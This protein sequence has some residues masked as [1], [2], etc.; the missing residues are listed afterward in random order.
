MAGIHDPNTIDLVTHD[1][2]TD[3]YAL[4]MIETRLWENSAEQIAQLRE[5][6]NTY[7]MYALDEGLIR[8]YPDAASKPLRI[9][10]DCV[11]PPNGEVADLIALAN[12]RLEEHGIRF[13]VNVLP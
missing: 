2:Q 7:A 5:K 8:A 10:L 1:P 12:K 3:E 9:Q 6:I 4:I 11:E 13:I